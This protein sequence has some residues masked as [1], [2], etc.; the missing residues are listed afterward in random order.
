MDGEGYLPAGSH[1]A[2]IDE[3][4]A[5]FVDGVGDSMHR[6]AVFDRYLQHR[7]MVRDACEFRLQ[8]IDG[9][10]VTSKGQP[11]DVD[12]ITVVEGLA[13]DALPQ[14]KQDLVRYLHRGHETRDSLGVDAFLLVRYT[15]GH[16][17]HAVFA[18]LEGHW[19]WQW[20]RIRGR[21]DRWKGFVEVAG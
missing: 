1:Q 12:V 9:S 4:K 14:H 2:T 5:A 10:F 18:A 21:G 8:R 7:A 6:A 17:E 20:S 11:A 15:E 16:P 13:F 19:T 3:L